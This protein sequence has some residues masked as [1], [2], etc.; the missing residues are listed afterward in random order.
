MMSKKSKKRVI[1]DYEK[2]SQELKTLLVETYPGGI[3][4]HIKPFTDVQGKL[5]YAVPLETDE[6]ILLIRLPFKM[7]NVKDEDED[8]EK[9][10]EANED[11]FEE[12]TLDEL[13]ED[14][15]IVQDEE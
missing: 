4:E 8:E 2:L 10:E 6:D 11:I 7:V 3:A 9:P 12:L 1:K 15:Y 5:F 13:D 14:E